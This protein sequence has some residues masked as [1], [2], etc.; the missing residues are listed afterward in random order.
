LIVGDVEEFGA[1]IETQRKGADP[2]H[3]HEEPTANEQREI[4]I[5]EFP[6]GWVTSLKAK[7]SVCLDDAS[8]T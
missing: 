2:E 7:T 1:K 4:Y 5:E 8:K 6:H 3:H